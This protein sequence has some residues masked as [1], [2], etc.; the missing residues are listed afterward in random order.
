MICILTGC[1]SIGCIAGCSWHGCFKLLCTASGEPVSG[2]CV[3]E[4]IVAS[5]GTGLGKPVVVPQLP[6]TWPRKGPCPAGPEHAPAY[7][8]GHMR[9][10]RQNGLRRAPSL[11]LAGPENAPE[12]PQPQKEKR[13]PD[14]GGGG[15]LPKHGLGRGLVRPDIKTNL[16]GQGPENRAR[17]AGPEH[18]PV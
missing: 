14:R 2:G 10:G 18:P 11:C 5:T 17:P 16:P 9:K 1:F 13:F 7:T 3:F 6:N 4:P 12:H 15:G 8:R